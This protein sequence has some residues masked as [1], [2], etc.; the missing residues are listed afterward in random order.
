MRDWLQLYFNTG[1]NQEYT[2]PTEYNS[3]PSNKTGTHGTNMYILY[4]HKQV[5]I[6]IS[7][8]MSNASYI[9]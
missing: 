4:T 2:F 7:G 8:K 5:L 1:H 3:E 9:T 6:Y